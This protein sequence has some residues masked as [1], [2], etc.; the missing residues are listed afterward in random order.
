MYLLTLC[1]KLDAKL[2]LVI[3]P[4]KVKSGLKL[5]KKLKSMFHNARHI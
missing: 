2:F 4:I 1:T 5:S 3:C